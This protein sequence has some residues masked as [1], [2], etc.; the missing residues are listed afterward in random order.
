M[1]IEN[2][3]AQGVHANLFSKNAVENQAEK[4]T[5]ITPDILIKAELAGREMASVVVDDAD[6]DSNS[7]KESRRNAT[8]HPQLTPPRRD[9]DPSAMTLDATTERETPAKIL[10][11]VMLVLE[12]SNFHKMATNADY[13]VSQH[14]MLRDKLEKIAQDYRAAQYVVAGAIDKLEV[15]KEPLMDATRGFEELGVQLADAE[16]VLAKMDPS[17]SDYKFAMQRRDALHVKVKVAQT[18]L[19]GL[20][21]KVQIQQEKVHVLLAISDDL[22]KKSNVEKM[23]IPSDLIESDVSNIARM[24]KLMEELSEVLLNTGDVRTEA[25]QKILKMQEEARI[26]NLAMNAKKAEE[27]IHRAEVLRT[28]MKW[29]GGFFA[30]LIGVIGVIGAVFT[31][32]ASLVLAAVLLTVTIAD[33]AGEAITGKSFMEKLMRPVA[34]LLEPLFKK[35]MEKLVS[36]YERMGMSPEAAR[37]AA[38][39]TLMIA[40]VVVGA[41]LAFTGIGSSIAKAAEQVISKLGSIISKIMENTINKLI[42]E[43]VQSS[44]KEM[45][46]NITRLLNKITNAIMREM[47]FSTDN[48][49]REMF[50]SR[51]SDIAGYGNYSKLSV[52]GAVK[53]AEQVQNLDAACSVAKIKFDTAELKMLQE[54]FSRLLEQSKNLF[55]KSQGFLNSAS[56]AIHEY[57]GTGVMLARAFNGSHSS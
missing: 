39:I 19:T 6:H 56:E 44:V 30:V 34:K 18:G 35:L 36:L 41:V 27:A 26:K 23:H 49:G 42:P 10:A 28:A 48:L 11:S 7:G 16:A 33:I 4:L 51:M 57:E 50:K 9:V 52:S 32:G 31:G 20:R 15:M 45:M 40:T 47:E 46:R 54:M 29:I 13:V 38:A 25:Q 5:G 8:M 17:L 12:K 53:V 22:L 3:A 14:A 1:S 37:N 55:S 21:D 2:L 24:L 43:V